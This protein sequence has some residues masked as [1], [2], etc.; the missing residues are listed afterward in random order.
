MAYRRDEI[1]AQ[2]HKNS[3]LEL[4]LLGVMH[5]IVVVSLCIFIA[6]IV[7]AARREIYLCSALIKQMESTHQAE[8]KSMNK[9]LAFASASHDVR[10]SLAIIT[11][12]IKLC[13]ESA[14]PNSEL[15]ANLVKMNADAMDLLG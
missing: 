9:S 5:V 8:R 4:I 6:L 10:N 15:A 12:L 3:K 1:E 13:H 7:R 11:G 14:D 2:V